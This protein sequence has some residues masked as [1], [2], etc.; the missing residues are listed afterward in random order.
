MSELV[1]LEVLAHGTLCPG[2]TPVDNLSSSWQES[3]VK[4]TCSPYSGQEEN[5]ARD[6]SSNIAFKACSQ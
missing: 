4:E 1:V 3:T 5:V 6:W 2:V